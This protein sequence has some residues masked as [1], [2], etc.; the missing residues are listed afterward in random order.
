MKLESLKDLYVEQL[1]DLH[2]AES[3]LLKALPK[4]ADAAATPQLKTAFREHL[5]QTRQHVERLETI[6]RNLGL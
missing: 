2:S 3:Q 1:R 6:F 5:E 4:M